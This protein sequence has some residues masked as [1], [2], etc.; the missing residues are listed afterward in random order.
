MRSR[1]ELEDGLGRA[2]HSFAYPHGYHDGTVRRFVEE[3]GY[4]SACGVK[5]VLSSLDDDPFSLGR[6][7]VTRD[8]D[9]ARLRRLLLDECLPIAPRRERLQTKGWRLARRASALVRGRSRAAP[10]WRTA[11]PRPTVPGG[12]AG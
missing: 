1:Q 3:A 10:S 6:V 9:A 4:T 11:E 7:I 2:V 8:V 5:H 12:Q